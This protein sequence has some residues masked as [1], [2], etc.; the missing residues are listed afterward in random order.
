MEILCFFAGIIFVYSK[1]VYSFLLVTL[2]LVFRLRWSVIVWFF[3]AVLW[4]LL[5]QVWV[6]DKGMPEAAV[7]S[8]AML[9]G[10][11]R[12]I[13]TSSASK[14]QL[15]FFARRL[16]NHAVQ[17]NIL[18][19]CYQH[20]PVFKAGQDW[21]LAA[22]LK[23]PRNLANLGS[24][25]YISWLKARHIHWTGYIKPAACKLQKTNNK[26]TL[27]ALREKLALRLN[28]LISNTQVL[29]IV[30]ALTLGL[31]SNV[32]KAQWDLFRRTGTT[33]LMVISG[34]HIGLL[35]GICFWLTR[36]LCCRLGYLCLYIPAAQLA[37]VAAVL[38]ALGYAL[39]AGFAVP[40][41]RALL[42]CFFLLLRYFL[43]HRYTVWQ[44]WRY[45]L[46]V[47][48]L[49]EPHAVLLPGFYLSFI[50]VAILIL[51]N[52][53]LAC[54]GIKKTIFIQLACLF[55][56]MPLSLYWFSYGAVN[57]L[58][59]NLVAIPWVGFVIVPLALLS[60]FLLQF[61]PVPQLLIPVN[62]AIKGLL[63]YLHW[64]DSFAL[65]NL[66][67]SFPELV[68][69]F[70]LMLAMLILLFLPIKSL[71]PA[72]LVLIGASFFPP[73]PQIK[74]GNVR[75]DILDVGQGLA[76]V[77]NTAKH[78]LVYDTGMKF[79]QGGDMAK[80]AIIPFLNTLGRTKLDKI[81]IS[82]PDLDHRGG[83]VALEERY[84]MAELLVDKVAF[85]HRGKGCHQYPEWQWDGVSFRFLPINKNFNDK[86]NNSCILLIKN[87]ARKMLFTGDIEKLAEDYLVATYGE[88][89]HADI[90][91]VPHHG[92]K[93]SSSLAFIKQVAAQHAVIS[94]GYDNRFHFPHQQTLQTL[95]Q[96]HIAVYNTAECGMVTI[97]LQKGNTMGLTCIEKC[98]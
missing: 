35:A 17:A 41:Q 94:A 47:V 22:K 32:D 75:I 78:T 69:P 88:Q 56:L 14:T 63:H 68:L 18:L 90:L 1:S 98:Q 58:V 37:S 65:F 16:N 66:Q 97:E 27:L 28:H 82:H 26:Q 34:A 67:V 80:L 46:F 61:F 54:T 52:Q 36:W 53:R 64:V 84:P 77:V 13:P 93:T 95:G 2:S 50:A 43:S 40:A 21:F 70:A 74:M 38:T 42:A 71:I 20:C 45:G 24:F 5:H 9:E 33:H 96:Q 85:Y 55:G 49:F 8:K 25:D 51:M 91:L 10:T 59:A 44:I 86:N 39:L 79:Y 3:A 23:R 7:I 48:M 4:A 6:K 60:L 12:S 83:L 87:T 29:G 57:G 19:S 62:L 11:V 76:V 72:T 92:S 30:Q 73:Y 89:L 31:T 81:I 15:Q